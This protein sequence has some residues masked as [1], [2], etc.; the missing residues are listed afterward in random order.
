[1]PPSLVELD[2][3]LSIAVTI[4]ALSLVFGSQYLLRGDI[5]LYAVVTA[6]A[7]LA[8]IPHELMHRWSA[9]V[10]GCYSRYVLYPLGLALTLITA[11][12]WIPVKIIMPGFTLVSVAEIDPAKL[13]RVDGLVSY[14]GPLTNILIASAALALHSVLL[15]FGALPAL[16]RVIILLIAELNAWIAV[17]NLLPIPPLDGSKILAWKPAL[18]ALTLALAIT[19]YVMPRILF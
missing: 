11:I 3:K 13:K 2:E 15:K 19:L 12:P 5:T 1:V 8:V 10:M 16:L 14:A 18:W 4:L 6:V 7:T 17:F 9:R